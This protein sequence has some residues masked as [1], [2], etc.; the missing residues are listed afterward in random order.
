VKYFSGATM[1]SKSVSGF[2][3]I[4]VMIVIA[5]MGIL[6]AIAAPNFRNYMTQSR[7]KGAARQVMSDLMLA[8]MQA[9]T[10]N[11]EVKVFFNA[12]GKNYTILDDTNNNGHY[13]GDPETE[14]TKNI[15][16]D[17]ND[18]SFSSNNNPIFMPRGTATSLPTVTL[19]NPSGS[20]YVKV[21]SAG[22]VKI[23]TVP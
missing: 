19:T 14:V 7:L 6:A 3:L 15:Q 5:I 16:T 18:V 9:V 17:Y 8:R 11:N 12:D 21:A 10:K 20:L 13:D 1:R 2:T 22:R 4:E 23:D